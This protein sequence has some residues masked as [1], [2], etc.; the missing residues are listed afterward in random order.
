MEAIKGWFHTLSGALTEQTEHS[1]ALARIAIIFAF[2]TYFF[3]THDPMAIVGLVFLIGALFWMLW[4]NFFPAVKVRPV[5]GMVADNVAIG[6]ALYLAGSHHPGLF[7]MY[8]W[9][10]IGNGYRFS[11][12][13]ALL[14]MAIALATFWPVVYFSVEWKTHHLEA[15]EMSVGYV[16]ISWFAYKLMS[17]L[18]QA[19][20]DARSHEQRADKL[21]T[22]TKRDGLTGLCNREAAYGLLNKAAHNGTRMAVLF[23]DLDNFKHFNDTYGHH[24]GDEVLVTIS[25]RLTNSVRNEDVVCRYAGDEF[26]ILVDDEDKATI[27]RVAR[28]VSEGLNTPLRSNE[29]QELKVTGSIGVAVLGI[30]GNTA[31]EVLRNADAAM[32]IAKRLGRNQVAWYEEKIGK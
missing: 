19:V 20:K 12:S 25:K 3:I 11:S 8:F 21:E 9:V 26:V 10:T 6:T 22:K 27:N 15:L 14:S 7:L 16:L 18:E 23:V 4:V 2:T 5:I 24:V 32:Y 13:Y 29:N 1:Q 17:N 28:R 31:S 30:H